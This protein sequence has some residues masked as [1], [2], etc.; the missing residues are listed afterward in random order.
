MDKKDTNRAKLLAELT[1]TSVLIVGVLF[2]IALVV[3]LVRLILF[4]LG[5]V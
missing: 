1:V 3:G 5:I 4:L 2:A